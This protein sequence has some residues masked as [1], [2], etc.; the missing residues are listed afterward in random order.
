[1]TKIILIGA[2]VIL[3]A[4]WILNLSFNQSDPGVISMCTMFLTYSYTVFYI[5][6]CIVLYKNKHE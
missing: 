5:G 1:M 6:L 2:T 3:V 4:L